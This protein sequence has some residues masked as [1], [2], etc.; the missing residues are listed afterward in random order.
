MH[1]REHLEYCRYS[2][3][4]L[5]VESAD[6]KSRTNRRAQS[7]LVFMIRS[8]FGGWAQIIGHHFT[9][10]AFPKDN[11]KDLIFSYLRV[12]HNASMRVKAIV[13]DQE[14]GHVS[15][16]K[17]LNV[18]RDTPFI[19]C[20]LCEEKIYIIYDPPHLLKSTRNNLITNNFL[21]SLM[22]VS[23]ILLQICLHQAYTVYF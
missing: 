14:P 7:L 15:L 2:D 1:L 11:L 9:Q 18:C 12:L 5:G 6:H 16:F 21:V 20:P 13:C 10:A 4:V 17:S 22:L 23:L 3:R 8:I 19:S